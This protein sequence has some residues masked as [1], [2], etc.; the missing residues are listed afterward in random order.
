MLS[1]QDLVYRVAMASLHGMT[2]TLV[3]SFMARLTGLEEFFTL[4]RGQLTAR[5]GFDSRIFDEGVRRK[6]LEEAKAET[7]FIVNHSVNAI[8]FTDPEYPRRL[9]ECDDAPVMIYALGTTDLNSAH[10]I[11]IVGTRHATVYGSGFVKD[12]VKDLHDTLAEPLVVVSGLAY[13]IDIAAHQAALDCGVPTVGVLAHGLNTIYPAT[14]RN[15]AV[16]MIQDGGMLMTDYRSLDAIHK[17]NFLARN[18]IVAGL[19]DCLLVAES[20][21]RGGAMV[22]ARL[23]GAYSRDV[24]A[25]PGRTS[26][27]YSRG[28][29]DLISRHAALLV[30]SGADIAEAMHWATREPEGTQTELF[31]EL[32]PDQEAIVALI[33]Q[34]GEA[35]LSEMLAN[36][37]ITTPRL[38][39]TLIDLEIK[40]IILSLP[41]ARYRLA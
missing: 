14:H 21:S 28:C 35:T 15:T 13:G 16:R 23:A 29:N 5:M 2:P 7:A 41:G 30:T 33:T 3:Q 40:N 10:F 24:F 22:T 4:S 31:P 36:I 18:R 38:M 9:L 37:D 26:D 27:R 12:V 6:A 17:G 32:S 11:S 8:Y 34:K 39:G 1:S 25:L 20:D 19:C